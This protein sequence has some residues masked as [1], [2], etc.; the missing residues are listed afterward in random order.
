MAE[1]AQDKDQKTHDATDRKL[2]QAREKGNVP[3]SREVSTFLMLL[4]LLVLAWMVFPAVGGAFVQAVLPFIESPD[5]IPLAT[6]EDAFHAAAAV[7][8]AMGLA[9]AAGVA[10]LVVGAAAS[11]FLQGEVVVAPDRLSPKPERLSPLK[12]IGRMVSRNGLVEFAKGILKTSVVL[13]V[14][15]LFLRPSFEQ[16]EWLVSVPVEGMLGA[17]RSLVIGLVAVLVPVA[18]LV[19]VG[20]RLYQSWEWRRGQRMTLREVKDELR[21]TEGDPQVKARRREI[22]RSR[23]RRRMMAQVPFASVVLVNPTHYAVA[24]RYE[25]GRDD[26]PVCVAK[27]QDRI[28][29]KIREIAREKGVPVIENPPLARAL[30][31]AVAV[32]QPIPEEHYKAV[33]EIISVILG[34]RRPGP[35]VPSS[36]SLIGRPGSGRSAG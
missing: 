27:G 20:D 8:R 33:A 23:A 11:A 7:I 26:A 12:G 15:A 30:H 19:A 18:G 22:G 28:A 17:I 34:L 9:L 29:L 5:L 1:E 32:D 13:L 10:L 3:R 2:E 35:A 31:A 25:R 14:T 24:L 16:A 4:T 36:T 6:A 21:S